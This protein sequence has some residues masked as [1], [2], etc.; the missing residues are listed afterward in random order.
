VAGITAEEMRTTEVTIHLSI[1]AWKAVM[2][3]DGRPTGEYASVLAPVVGQEVHLACGPDVAIVPF[4]PDLGPTQTDIRVTDGDLE[5]L[6]YRLE[7]FTSGRKYQ[8]VVKEL[9]IIIDGL[10]FGRTGEPINEAVGQAISGAMGGPVR[11]YERG[12]G[13]ACMWRKSGAMGRGT[14]GPIRGV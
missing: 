4:N 13:W 3:G 12:S 1:L 2:G 5:V 9:P 6:R 7:E 11:G 10:G 8:E 14:G